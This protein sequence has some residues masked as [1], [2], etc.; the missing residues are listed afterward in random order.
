[1]GFGFP[2]ADRRLRPIRDRPGSANLPG[3][4]TSQQAKDGA[5]QSFVRVSRSGALIRIGV[6]ERSSP[7]AGLRL[8]ACCR[9]RIVGAATVELDGEGAPALWIRVSPGWRDDGV[10]ERLAEVACEA[11][12]YR[13][14]EPIFSQDDAPMAED[15]V[16]W[17]TSV[18]ALNP[19]AP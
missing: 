8:L 13:G 10:H 14:L 11:A 19:S 18:D 5:L 1:M 15:L 2:A 6:W 9:G 7:D 4:V 3:M 17:L 12:A 16:H